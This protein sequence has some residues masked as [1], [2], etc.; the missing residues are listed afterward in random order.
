MPEGRLPQS[1]LNSNLSRPASPADCALWCDILRDRYAV[2]ADCPTAA[3]NANLIL[4][5]F[6]SGKQV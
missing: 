1:G 6:G 2:T 3:K 4:P 5:L